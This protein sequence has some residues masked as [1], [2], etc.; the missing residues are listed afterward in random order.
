M[1]TA[2]LEACQQLLATEGRVMIFC[3][4]LSQGTR[5]GCITFVLILTSFCLLIV[6]VQ[7]Y[8]CMKEGRR[9]L[10]EHRFMW[11]ENIKVVLNSS[12]V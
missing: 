12:M 10:G 8:C 4:A 5:V 3:A 1:K 7:G 11:Q 6:G 2:R 9:P